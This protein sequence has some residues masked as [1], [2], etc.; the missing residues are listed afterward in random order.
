V[1]STWAARVG[2]ADPPL[3]QPTS[4]NL[5]ANLQTARAFG[6]SISPSVLQQATELIQ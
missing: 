6:L 1:Q 4:F 2:A 5:V 3:E